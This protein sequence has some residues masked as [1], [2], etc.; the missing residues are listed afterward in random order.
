MEGITRDSPLWVYGWIFHLVAFASKPVVFTPLRPE[1]EARR[2][3]TRNTSNSR[4]RMR[5]APSISYTSDLLSLKSH[6]R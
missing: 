6:R 2:G 1:M 3:A 4:L 5:M